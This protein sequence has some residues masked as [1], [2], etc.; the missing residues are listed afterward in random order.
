MKK[1]ITIK[2]KYSDVLYWATSK[3]AK[4]KDY[5][6]S[7]TDEAVLRKLMHYD[8]SNPKITY[9]NSVIAEHTF[10]GEESIK[11]TIPKLA[12]KKFISTATYKIVD[13]GAVKTR[14]TIFVKWDFI[15][16]VLGDIPEVKIEQ[17]EKLEVLPIL[18]DE[19]TILKPE[20]LS[21]E[22]EEKKVLPIIKNNEDTV[23]N[24]QYKQIEVVE[25]KHNIIITDEK[26]SWIGK[27]G[28][29]DF[30]INDIKSLSQK[31]LNDLYYGNNGIWEI[32]SVNSENRYLIRLYYIGG[33][34]CKLI[35]Y[36]TND[37]YIRLD[38]Y[39]L[40]HLLGIKNIGFGQLTSKLYYQIKENGLEKRPQNNRTVTSYI[41]K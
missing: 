21:A 27:K 15:E 17:K 31:D 28:Y 2:N 25:E 41:K 1:N 12:K 22:L 3:Q 20:E 9:S 7:R 24:L 39:D 36:N 11:K 26:F 37:E 35:N 10:I 29:N 16:T 32:D 4:G 18:E 19:T 40:Q 23:T 8:K 13:A 5:Q 38:Y 30:S 33:S 34:E 6:I 14:R